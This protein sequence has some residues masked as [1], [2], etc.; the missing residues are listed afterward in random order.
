MVHVVFP[1]ENDDHYDH[2]DHEDHGSDKTSSGDIMLSIL[3]FRINLVIKDKRLSDWS[4]S[5]SC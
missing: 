4:E 5:G 3:A 1:I 2:D